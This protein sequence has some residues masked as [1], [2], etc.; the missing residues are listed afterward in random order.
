MAIGYREILTTSKNNTNAKW[1]ERGEGSRLEPFAEPSFQTRVKL[2]SGAKV[3]TMGSCFARNIE[4]YFAGEG[5]DVPVMGY[6]A[7]AEEYGEGSRIQGILNKYT[8][9]SIAIEIEWLARVRNEGGKVTW[10]NIEQMMLEAG[11]D[12]VFDLQLSTNIAVSKARAVERRQQIY[13]IHVQMFDC[14]L[15]VL[16]PGLTETWLD[17]KTGL[18]IQR[19]PRPRQVAAHPD[20]FAFEVMDFFQCFDMLEKLIKTLK[21]N[22]TKQIA[23]TIS[24]VPLLRTMTDKDVLIANTY[25][26]STLRSAVGLICDRYEFVN[27][28]PSYEKVM[29]SKSNSVWQDDLRHVADGFVGQIASTFAASTGVKLRESN[30]AVTAFNAAFDAERLEEATQ[31]LDDMG[32]NALNVGVFGFHKNAAKV[33][34]K[35]RRWQ[36]ALPHIDQI[37]RLRPHSPRGYKMEYRTRMKLDDKAGA[38]DAVQRAMQNCENLSKEEFSPERKRG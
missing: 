29:L 17:T 22:G 30:D 32:D 25:S 38:E 20:R 6:D 37:Q 15:V 9:A 35:T 10:E 7:P 18:Y 8:L 2:Q 31:L 13:D 21:E 11:D 1:P 26:K 19:M 12:Q 36:D 34:L 28:V 16:T 4:E 14:D 24:P 27:Y 5:F 33:L 23:M 3:L